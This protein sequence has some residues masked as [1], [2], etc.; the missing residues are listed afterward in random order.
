MCVCVCVCVCVCICVSVCLF[1]ASRGIYFFVK[2]P[3]LPVSKQRD[4]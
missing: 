3:M 4:V 2:V 1:V